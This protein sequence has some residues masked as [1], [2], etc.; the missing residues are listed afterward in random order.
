[1]ADLRDPLPPVL[2]TCTFHNARPPLVRVS[3][4]NSI[5]LSNIPD[6]RGLSV[7]GT[8]YAGCPRVALRRCRERFVVRDVLLLFSEA[9]RSTLVNPR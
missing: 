8:L 6:T 9:F 7:W 1:M 3:L 2:Q 4:T 5:I